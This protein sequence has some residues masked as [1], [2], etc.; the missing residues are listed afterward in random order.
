MTLALLALALGLLLLFLASRLRSRTGLP[1][2]TVAYQ[3]TGGRRPERPLISRR[4]GLVGQ[5]DYLLEERG[6]L[7]P[8]E[9]KP[10]RGARSP[11]ESDIMQLA[12]YCLLV[13]DQ[14][15]RA[16]THGL[17]RYKH[18]TFQIDWTPELREEL[19]AI[20]EELRAD[21]GPDEVERSHDEPRRCAGC[22]FSD[23][24]DESLA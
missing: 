8:V 16:P 20:L 11:Y 15:G 6:L 19:L 13:E 5:P 24:C 10:G 18:D 7:I 14:L 17:L 9:V 12:A 2:R 22:G 23:R 3:D 21:M 4:Y 1:W